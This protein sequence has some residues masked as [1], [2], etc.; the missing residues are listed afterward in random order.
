MIK[1]NDDIHFIFSGKGPYENLINKESEK[2]NIHNIGITQSED[3][4]AVMK[5]SNL[6]CLPSRS[7]GFCIALLEAAACKLPSLITKV[8]IAD[9][10]IINN[11]FGFILEKRDR[12]EIAKWITTLYNKKDT[13]LKIGENVYKEVL[14]NYSWSNTAKKLLKEVD[15]DTNE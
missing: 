12:K 14:A 3:V 15:A 11:S 7:E 6:M 1:N 13:L 2:L 10:L 5:H 9:K 4:A 8:G